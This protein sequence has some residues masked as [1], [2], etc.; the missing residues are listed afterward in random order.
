[1]NTMENENTH[2]HFYGIISS[3]QRGDEIK[4]YIK[5]IYNH[6]DN[7]GGIVYIYSKDDK[8]QKLDYLA[9]TWEVDLYSLKDQ[10]KII[11]ICREDYLTN[12]HMDRE[13]L[14]NA[15]KEGL[16]LLIKNGIENRLVFITIDAFWGPFIKD[17][18]QACYEFIR[19]ISN[20][21]NTKFV[22]RYIMEE[23][24]E[25]YIHSLFINHEVLLID[26]VNDFELYT[27][28]GL[29]YKATILLSKYSSTVY[30]YEKEMMKLEYLRTLGELMEGTVHDV[31]N[32]LITILGYAQLAQIVEDEEDINKSLKIIQD[33]AMDG[34]NIVD[35]IQNHIRGSYTYSKDVYELDD[36]VETCINMT[37][38]KFKPSSINRIADINIEVDLNSKQFIYGNEYE[39]RQSIINIILNGIDAIEGYGTMTIKTYNIDGKAVLEISDTGKGMDGIT[40]NKIF[41]PYFSTKGSRG[42]G[43]GLSI[44]KK[45]FENHEAEIRVESKIG[46]GTKF[47]IYFPINEILYNVAENE[48]KDYNII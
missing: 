18:G 22:L 1:M 23:L 40:I 17:D 41:N 4:P 35:R 31:N 9:K 27:P 42:T 21:E 33:T 2:C 44:A 12:N 36:I 15:I 37:A 7:N 13:G 8:K 26:G 48:S 38:H 29:M 43:L 16:N 30:K 34:K 5:N 19:G 46:K 11:F 32:L 25:S 6:F 45:V 10:G 24:F 28:E 14:R 47:T 3:N 20:N 39:L